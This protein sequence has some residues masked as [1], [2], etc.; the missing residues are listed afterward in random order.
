MT[1]RYTLS[2]KGTLRHFLRIILLLVGSVALTLVA[3]YLGLIPTSNAKAPGFNALLLLIGVVAFNLL[4]QLG[5][6]LDTKD[7]R[8]ALSLPYLIGSVVVAVVIWVVLALT[9][10]QHSFSVWIFIID[11]IFLGIL[12]YKSYN[13]LRNTWHVLS[14]DMDRND[15]H[16]NY[17]GDYVLEYVHTRDSLNS[18]FGRVLI[19]GNA[20][21]FVVVNS[22]KG[23]VLIDT[24]EKLDIRRERLL[25]D[26]TVSDVIDTDLMISTGEEGVQHIMKI[27]Q[28]ECARRGVAVPNMRYDFVM[29]L[30]RFIRGNF[31]L[32]EGSFRSIPFWDRNFLSYKSYV[33]EAALTNTDIF[34]GKACCTVDELKW[35]AARI[36]GSQ[37]DAPE[38]VRSNAALVADCIAKACDLEE[39]KASKKRM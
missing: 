32:D 16:I 3:L 19:I 4:M 2:N 34:C 24:D 39:V 26:D 11:A 14:D 10:K 21:L 12:I 37:T 8:K 6:Y 20:V 33:K 13:I 29:F 25:H 30:P 31:V 15:D 9:K 27:V 36:G 17:P 18:P 23:H 38:V 7:D 1:R 5:G 22:F 35:A 28:E